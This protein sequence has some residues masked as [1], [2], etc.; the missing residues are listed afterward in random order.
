M[1]D[2]YIQ[3]IA[4]SIT[5]KSNIHTANISDNYIYKDSWGHHCYI[6]IKTI[7][8]VTMNICYEVCRVPRAEPLLYYVS[9]DNMT[10]HSQDLA[11]LL[12][13]A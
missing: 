9:N 3:K 1:C 8:L 6:I 5:L 7:S 4:T 13:V 11:D 12:Q 2:T 10:R